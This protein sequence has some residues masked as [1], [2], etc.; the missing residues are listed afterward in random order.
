MKTNCN[1]GGKVEEECCERNSKKGMFNYMRITDDLFQCKP[2]FVLFKSPAH[3]LLS[4]R[5]TDKNSVL[6]IRILL[7]N[8]TCN[9]YSFTG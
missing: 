7:M 3:V 1:R 6:V 5:I 8:F 9:T 4:D 2:C